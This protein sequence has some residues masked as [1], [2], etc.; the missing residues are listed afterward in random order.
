M[1]KDLL[2][3]IVDLGEKIGHVFVVTAGAS[4]VSHLA[5]A[6]ELTSPAKGCVAMKAWSCQGAASTR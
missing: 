2:K 3:K 6:R 4:G 1:N 5:V